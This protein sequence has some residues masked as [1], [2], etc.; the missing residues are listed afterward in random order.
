MK[1]FSIVVL[2]SCLN[3]GVARAQVSIGMFRG[4]EVACESANSNSI[5]SASGEGVLGIRECVER[6]TEDFV[7]RSQTWFSLVPQKT[8]ASLTHGVLNFFPKYASE[9]DVFKNAKASHVLF[10]VTGEAELKKSDI[11]G[12]S[13]FFFEGNVEVHFENNN[14]KI[15]C[16][17]SN[18]PVSTATNIAAAPYCREISLFYSNSNKALVSDGYFLPK[19]D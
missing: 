17:V 9:S 6:A 5:G 4:P 10:K 8:E 7:N 18:T 3:M 14:G 12:G 11:R 19:R 1:L 16:Y 15:K 13:N 2:F